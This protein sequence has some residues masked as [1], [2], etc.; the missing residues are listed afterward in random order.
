[1]LTT[2]QENASLRRLVYVGDVPVEAS[3][4]GSALLFRLLQGYP[5][6]RIRIIEGKLRSSTPNRR[7]P[8]V[9]YRIFRNGSKRYLNSRLHG[10]YSS[11]LMETAACRMRDVLD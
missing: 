10:L 11:W 4:H 1:M 2:V 5:N 6:D 3:H 8:G 7:L 9:S